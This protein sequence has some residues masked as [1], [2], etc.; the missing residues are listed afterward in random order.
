MA[1]SI[2]IYY[3]AWLRERVGT[4]LE[5]LPLPGSV[6]TVADLM[7]YLASRETPQAAVFRTPVGIRC[8]VNRHFADAG[9]PISPGDEVAFFPPITGG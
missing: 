3:F 9:S 6:R 4:A 8:A 2:T 5:E 7:T 1:A